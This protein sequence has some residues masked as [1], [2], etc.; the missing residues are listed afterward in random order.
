MTGDRK[1]RKTPKRPA[2]KA[3]QRTPDK[4]RKARA[5]VRRSTVTASRAKKR[6]STIRTLLGGGVFALL[7]AL[8][9]GIHLGVESLAERGFFRVEQIEISGNARISEERILARLNLPE[10]SDLWH[11]DLETVSTG[12]LSHPWV[13]RVSIRRI[14]PHTVSIHLWE[15]TPA[16]IVLGQTPTDKKR[17]RKD[18]APLSLMVDSEGVVLGA[19]EP[20]TRGLPRLTGIP[21]E[22]MVA[23]DRLDP[24]RIRR[25][26]LVAHAYR[27]GKAPTVDVANP[28]DPL[29][30]V[31]GMRVRLGEAGTYTRHLERLSQLRESLRDVAGKHGAEVD[32]RFEDRVIARPL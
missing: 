23:G 22:G 13:E 16:A 28:R 8:G 1:P 5:N 14:Y 6:S 15:R 31:D 20:G 25:G 32:L 9:W 24:A 4:P 12:V 17:R 7:V 30:L 11:L 10:A 3:A 27:G 29:L 21:I 26:L 2:A 19:P 18:A